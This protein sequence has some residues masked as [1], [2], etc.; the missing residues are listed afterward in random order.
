MTRHVDFLKELKALCD[1]YDASID[2]C[3]CCGSPFVTVGATSFDN[4]YVSSKLDEVKIHGK[5]YNFK[6][7]VDG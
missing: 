5:Q 4:L 6:D 1:K 3:G 7:D 2:G